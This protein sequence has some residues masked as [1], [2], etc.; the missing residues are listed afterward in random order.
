MSIKIKIAALIVVLFIVYG[1]LGDLFG[2][3]RPIHEWRKT[4]SF[5]I[6]LNYMN[7]NS[8]LQPETQYI[9]VHNNR[10]AA[11][12]FPIIYYIVGKLWSLF[13]QHEWIGKILSYL[14]LYAALILFSEVLH[15]FFRS[16]KKTILFAATILSSPVLVFYSNT[17]L[18]NIFSFSFLLISAYIIYKYLSQPRWHLVPLLILF[19]TLAVLVKITALIAILTFAGAAIIHYGFIKKELFTLYR[20]PAFIF[21]LTLILALLITWQ[22]YAYAIRYNQFY[23]SDLFSTV[24]RPIWEVSSDDITRIWNCI[25]KYQFNLLFHLGVLIPVFCFVLYGLFSGK[26]KG[27]LFCTLIM[28]GIGVGAYVMLWFWA[29]EVHD[30]YLIEILFFPLMMLFIILRDFDLY[31]KHSKWM[32]RGVSYIYLS[33]IFFHALAYSQTS[34]GKNNVISQNNILLSS[35]IRGN[36]RYFNDHYNTHLGKLQTH[37][38]EVRNVILPADTVICINDPSPN[39]QLYTVGRLGVTRMGFNREMSDS[40]NIAALI[41]RGADKILRV[42]EEC[43]DTSAKFFFTD[44]LLSHDGIYV[45]DLARYKKPFD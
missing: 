29:L 21:L 30:Y 24:V 25:W 6:A 1:Q 20:K 28:G 32:K 2:P 34:G 22:W 12:E 23:H 9:S 44:T 4:D 5:S 36:W 38:D 8:F 7:G 15:Y 39:I 14:I 33:L 42:G 10:A 17:I 3:I 18:P 19:I 37:L 40:S 31:V 26:I 16:E 41:E 45:F 35:F 27:F 43:S 13:G 11:G